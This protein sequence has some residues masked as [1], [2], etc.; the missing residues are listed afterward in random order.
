MTMKRTLFFLLTLALAGLPTFIAPRTARADDKS[1][2]E[3]GWRT[4]AR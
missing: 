2:D 1:K 3:A 4:P